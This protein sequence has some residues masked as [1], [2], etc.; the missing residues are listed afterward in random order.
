M[1]RPSISDL[2]PP[3]TGL[4]GWP[5]TDA[6]P[7]VPPLAPTGDT[8]PRISIVTPSFNQATYIEKTIRSVLLQGYPNLEYLVIDGGSRDG[9]AEI[10]RKYQPWLTYAVSEPDQGQSDAIR[11][12]LQRCSGDLFN[13]LN[14]DDILHPG[15]L[16]MV[17]A[18]WSPDRP[19]LIAGR[20][21]VI[22]SQSGAVKHDWPARPPRRL[23]D[24]LT[25]HGLVLSQPSTFIALEALRTIGGIRQDLH[26][27]MDWE[28][29]LRLTM[30]LGPRLRTA[31]TPATLSSALHHPD[32]KTMHSLDRFTREADRLLDDLTPQL[33]GD[34]RRA[35]DAY[36]RR[37]RSQRLIGFLLQRPHGLAGLLCLPFQQPDLLRTRFF[38]GALRRATRPLRRSA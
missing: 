21:L 31:T 35:L 28:L 7:R 6:S 9:S 20:G 36:M 4:S 27:V 17:G 1:H 22:D 18:L 24:F 8:W 2:P 12:G 38:W 16:A 11:K 5:W 19:H 30:Q 32:A 26:F 37:L 25:P 13:W 34:E 23:E 33:W 29:Y 10:I 15:A 3:P 14:S